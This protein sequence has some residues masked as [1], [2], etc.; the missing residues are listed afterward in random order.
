VRGRSIGVFQGTQGDGN[1]PQYLV[2]SIWQLAKS[3]TKPELRTGQT[4]QIE[5]AKIAVI[6]GTPGEVAESA[7]IDE[8]MRTPNLSR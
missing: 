8:Q 3:T 5:I 2:L 4:E 7:K 1:R 6:H